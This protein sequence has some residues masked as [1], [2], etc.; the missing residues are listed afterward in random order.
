M[1]GSC[2]CA[3]GKEIITIY[4]SEFG[5]PIARDRIMKINGEA[6]LHD[7]VSELRPISSDAVCL[8][9]LKPLTPLH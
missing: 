4:I 6:L 8:A 3:P 7:E 5:T 2:F 9:G 1:E